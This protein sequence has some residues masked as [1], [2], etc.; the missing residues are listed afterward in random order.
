MIE[1]GWSSGTYGWQRQVAMLLL[2]CWQSG[3]SAG[4]SSLGSVASATALGFLCRQICQNSEHG[5]LILPHV[6]TW[7]HEGTEAT[8]ATVCI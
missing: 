7:R 2:Q 4:G 8:P 6:L 5:S 3:V 1:N